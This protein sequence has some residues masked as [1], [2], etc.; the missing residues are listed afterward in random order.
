M[1]VAERLARAGVTAAARRWPADIAGTLHAE[2]LAELAALRGRP[3]RMLT[4]AAGL[5]LSPAV[6]EPGWRDRLAG[7]GRAAAVAAGAT[8]LAAGLSNGVHVL[9]DGLLVA[10][11]AVTAVAGRRAGIRPV[12]L[13]PLL[14]LA[15]FAFLMAGNE[16]P[17][18]P[19][20]GVAD[21]GPAVVTW[22]VL[23]LLT[24][25]LRHGLAVAAGGLGTLVAATAAGSWHAAG[26]LGAGHGSAPAWFALTL[27][28]GGT[29]RFGPV[30]HG[31]YASEVLLGNAAAMTVPMLLATV[32]VLAGRRPVAYRVAARP[33][34]TIPA[35]VAAALAGLAFCELM[36][37]SAGPVEATLQRVVDS[38]AAF[39]F[40]FAAH[41]AGRALVALAAALLVVR[42]VETRAPVRG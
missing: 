36:R 25:R 1:S 20:M 19:F 41:P 16:V 29:A 13:T 38:S 35:G 11:V 5:A 14:G 32:F 21:V 3:W 2:W 10:A 4:F 12:V 17:V 33:R 9:G 23:M 31:T 6:D 37:R 40:G 42:L 27:L 26:V 34:V 7:L 28:P 22:T 18:M 30:S 39:G 24:V 15:M 8:V